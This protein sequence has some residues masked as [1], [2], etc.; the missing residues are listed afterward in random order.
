MTG[1]VVG[2]L[3]ACTHPQVAIASGGGRLPVAFKP[4]ALPPS[5]SILPGT[6]AVLSRFVAPTDRFR[7]GQPL[8]S[9]G[10]SAFDAR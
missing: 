4:V 5:R 7:R 2:L 10:R 1:A 6:L 9:R 3:D 8:G